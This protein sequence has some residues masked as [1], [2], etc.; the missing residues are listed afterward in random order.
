MLSPPWK[1]PTDQCFCLVHSHQLY[2]HRSDTT[3]NESGFGSIPSQYS[4][5]GFALWSNSSRMDCRQGWS[6]QYHDHSECRCSIER[7]SEMLTIPSDVLLYINPDLGHVDTLQGKR[8]H[9]RI[10]GSLWFQLRRIRFNGP[11]SDCSVS[12]QGNF[13]Q[14]GDN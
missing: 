12:A 1:H 7:R 11:F 3:G 2:H 10:R 14:I 13:V 5:R 6:L 9:H 4:Q 8:T